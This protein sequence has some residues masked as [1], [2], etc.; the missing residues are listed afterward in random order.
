VVRKRSQ[1]EKLMECFRE[2]VG[3]AHKCHAFILVDEFIS[4]G[5]GATLIGGL[6]EGK[7]L[8]YLLNLGR[9]QEFDPELELREALYA[10]ALLDTR[11][12]PFKS[13][14]C[15]KIETSRPASF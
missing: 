12:C 4:K 3:N 6:E 9:I 11:I 1:A 5:W 7:S 13:T 14:K 8:R 10:G 15:G 2:T